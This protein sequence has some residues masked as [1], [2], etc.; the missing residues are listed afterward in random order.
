MRMRAPLCVPIVA[1]ILPAA[2]LADGKAFLY[3]RSGIRPLDQNEQ[4]AAIHHRDGVQ[5]MLIAINVDLE[6]SEDGLWIFPVCGTPDETKLDLV[7]QFP[8][9][10]GTDVRKR[11]GQDI[12]MLMA[13]VRATQLYPCPPDLLPSLARHRGLNDAVHTSVEKWGIRAVTVSPLS[14]AE[15]AAFLRAER[16]GVKAE[17]LAGFEPYFCDEYVLV[18]AWLASRERFEE[19]FPDF[20]ADPYRAPGG[21]WPC[22]LVEFPTDQAFY[23]MRPTATYGDLEMRVRLYVLGY[24]EP[25]TDPAFARILDVDHYEQRW[26]SQKLPVEFLAGLPR[27]RIPYTRVTTWTVARNF[28]DDLRFAPVDLPGL[29][30]AEHVRSLTTPALQAASWFVVVGVLAYLSGGVAGLLV[31]RRW[32]RPALLGLWNWLTLL[33]LGLALHRTKVESLT[34]RTEP[35]RPG[36]SK[37]AFLLVFTVLFVVGSVGLQVMLTRPL[38]LTG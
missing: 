32:G 29:A 5:R 18:V 2:V 33:G 19:E 22:L 23:P 20:E 17:D 9:F 26:L 4:I 12:R 28:I 24:V 8:D 6:D 30:Y 31:F 25:Q 10:R 7:D 15:L 14:A 3:D 11:A 16:P 13:L 27:E 35:P 38:H 21:R 36:R 37:V 1:A 34:G